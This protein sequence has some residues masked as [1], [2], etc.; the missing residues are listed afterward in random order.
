MLK[1]CSND[2][3]DLGRKKVVSQTP[4]HLSRRKEEV[5]TITEYKGKISK[6]LT[7]F[8][9]LLGVLLELFPPRD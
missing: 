5:A 3:N 8:L 4:C 9:F 2:D 6:N 7:F 1:V